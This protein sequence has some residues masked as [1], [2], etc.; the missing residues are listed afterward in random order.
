[1]TTAGVASP[2]PVALAERIAVGVALA[3]AALLL[4][5]R[6]GAFSAEF[7]EHVYLA[8][9][10]LLGRGLA[11]GSD[12]FVSQP[13]LFFG[14][15]DA[16]YGLLGGDPEAVRLVA[17]VVTLAGVLGGWAVVRSIAGGR[18]A[19]IAVAL[20]VLS[21]GVVESAAVVSADL[22]AMA[23]GTGALVAA[24]WSRRAG[25]G[26]ATAGWACVAG[27]LLVA[28][29]L[30][31]LLAVV[32]AVALLSTA[33]AQWPSRVQVG[34]FVT[35]GLLVAGATAAAY[36]GA[37]GALWD[38]AVGFHLEARDTVPIPAPKP[39]GIVLGMT[40]G[41]VGLV[42]LAAAGALRVPREELRSWCA[43]RAD[44]LGLLAGGLLLCA[45]QRPLLQHHLVVVAWPLA[46]LAAS[47]LPPRP[48]P[49]AL[50]AA[51]VGLALL[52]PWAG[53]G[54]PTID[55]PELERVR[56]AAALVRA[57]TAPGER[58]V[59]DL[60]IV[61]LLAARPV[62]PATAD[63][64]YVRVGTG[65]LD[66]ATVLRAGEDAGAVVV[67]RAFERLP[68]LEAALRR[69]FGPPAL[70]GDVRVYLRRTAAGAAPPPTGSA[71]R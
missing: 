28:A 62:A 3:I 18:A 56:A 15:L 22:P 51:V 14:L 30:V 17:V 1:M 44:L 35:G 11:A 32:F 38:G 24:R 7:D 61:P 10:D 53:H 20:L 6:I 42:A 23:L 5:R 40:A 29:V 66:R 54:R 25:R 65:S 33:V 50:V 2:A 69:R 36:A 63:P 46:L 64:S 52:V 71:R 43:A 68:G 8:T 31:K 55:E 70:N 19:L 67:G 48:G 16:A 12:V 27:A 58:V 39:L 26:R 41:F 59:S 34:A 4:T 13:P 45:V 60:P 37:L 57:R 47:S 9:A 49:R 21:P